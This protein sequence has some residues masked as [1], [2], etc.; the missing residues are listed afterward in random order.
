MIFFSILLPT[1][2]FACGDVCNEDDGAYVMNTFPNVAPVPSCSVGYRS[3]P[4]PGYNWCMRLYYFNPLNY[5]DAEKL[6]TADGAVPTGFQ[7]TIEQSWITNTAKSTQSAQGYDYGGIWLGLHITIGCTYPDFA[8]DYPICGNNSFAWT[9]GYTTGTSQIGWGDLGP[10]YPDT[11]Q[12]AIMAAYTYTDNYVR[13][14][15][16]NQV[17][18]FDCSATT[19]TYEYE[20]MRTIVCGKVPTEYS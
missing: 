11:Y 14:I 16:P 3:F 2:I 5:T 13:R 6:C 7:N 20:T 17:E 9:D 8:D 18:N 12:C 1:I 4:R 10:I 15:N 19:G